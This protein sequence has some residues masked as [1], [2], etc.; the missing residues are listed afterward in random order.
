MLMI[1]FQRIGRKNDP[2]FR[3]VV[4]EKTSGP[5]A[6]SYVDLVGTYNPK[7]KQVTLKPDAILSWMG[8]GA[9]VSPSLHNLL[10]KE[11]VL[12]GKKFAVVSKKNLEKNQGKVEKAGAAAPATAAVETPATEATAET[13]PEDASGSEEVTVEA[14]AEMEA[15]VEAEAEPAP[16]EVAASEE[17]PVPAE[18]APVVAEVPEEEKAA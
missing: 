16:E 10:V 14:P 7:T 4:L 11:G 8:K 13:V 5:K 1:R 9:Q 6:G 17:A 2:A 3:I 12:E 15:T 18:E